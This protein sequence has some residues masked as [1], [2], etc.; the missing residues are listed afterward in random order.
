M[1]L[2]AFALVPRFA[3]RAEAFVQVTPSVI[4]RSE[5]PGKTLKGKIRV[6]NPKA[7]TVLVTPEIRDCKSLRRKH[8]CPFPKTNPSSS[9]RKNPKPSNTS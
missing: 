8:G 2:V 7:E 6:T 9:A 1:V 4:E 3:G 5:T